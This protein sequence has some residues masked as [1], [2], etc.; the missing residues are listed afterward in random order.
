[1]AE[2][3]GER[4]AVFTTTESHEIL[5]QGR[6]LHFRCHK[7]KGRSPTSQEE[8]G[9]REESNQPGGKGCKGGVQHRM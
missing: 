6:K 1:M 7:I 9:A 3:S 4:E 2:Q 5:K 8:R